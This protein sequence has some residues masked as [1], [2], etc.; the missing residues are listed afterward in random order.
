MRR[1]SDESKSCRAGKPA[2]CNRQIALWVVATPVVAAV[3]WLLTSPSQGLAAAG[4]PGCAPLLAQFGGDGGPLPPTGRHLADWKLPLKIGLIVACALIVAMV[5]YFVVY[6]SVLRR[7]K[8]PP[9]PLTLF[10]RCTAAA[11]FMIWMIGLVV[12]WKEMVIRDEFGG[13]TFLGEHGLRMAVVAV[14]V[15]FAVLWWF[16][17][18]SDIAAEAKQPKPS[19]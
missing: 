10:G 2:R 12:F 18:R 7:E 1:F 17:W 4:E 3:A 6:P 16:V 8:N 19:K 5:F 11:W 9:W 13:T 14:A 15:A